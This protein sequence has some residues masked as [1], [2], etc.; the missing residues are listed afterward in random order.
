[1]LLLAA[2]VHG[3]AA[4]GVIRRRKWS[5]YLSLAICVYWV[6]EIGYGL[7][8]RGT[9]GGWFSVLFFVLGAI[10]L[11]WLLIPAARSQFSLVMP[12]K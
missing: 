9:D 4:W 2:F 8:T 7:V 1:M 11:A 10:A 5:Y 3:V 12:K 6:I